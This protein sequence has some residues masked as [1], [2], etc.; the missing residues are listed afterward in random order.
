MG[1]GNNHQTWLKNRP[2]RVELRSHRDYYSLPVAT[3]LYSSGASAPRRQ[4]ILSDI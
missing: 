1:L 2:P 3:V 4:L